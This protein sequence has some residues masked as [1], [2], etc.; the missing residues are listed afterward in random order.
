LHRGAGW[1]GNLKQDWS[2]GFPLDDRGAIPYPPGGREVL[3]PQAD[4]IAAAKLAVFGQVEHRKVARA[5]LDLKPHLDGPDV[6]RP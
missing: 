4:E 6:F 5:V 2:S 3:N 1:L